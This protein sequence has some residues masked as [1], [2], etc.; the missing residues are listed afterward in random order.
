MC[1]P[2]DGVGNSYHFLGS[3]S[4]IKILKQ[5]LYK[6]HINRPIPLYQTTALQPVLVLIG[7]EIHEYSGYIRSF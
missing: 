1:C 7:T 6:Q 4:Y 5:L 2:D 3:K